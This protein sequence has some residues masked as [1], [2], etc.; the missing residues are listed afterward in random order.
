MNSH[1]I[2]TFT[3]EYCKCIHIKHQIKR[4]ALLILTNGRY[5]QICYSLYN[6]TYV[7]I[8]DMINEH[9]DYYG[10]DRFN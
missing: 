9:C 1:N 6:L 4:E 3:A 2:L 7:N 8:I 10:V 5:I